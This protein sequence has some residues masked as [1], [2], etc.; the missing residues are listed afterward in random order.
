[1]ELRDAPIGR[2]V[3]LQFSFFNG[4]YLNI[5]PV[6]D[7]YGTFSK[8]AAAIV[9]T[10]VIGFFLSLPGY[11]SDFL[12]MG[13]FLAAFIVM[14]WL[15]TIPRYLRELKYAFLLAILI[16]VFA[17]YL[18][19]HWLSLE[20]FLGSLTMLVLTE[21]FY[22]RLLR[23]R[24]RSLS[25]SGS[26]SKRPLLPEGLQQHSLPRSLVI[27][28]TLPSFTTLVLSLVFPATFLWILPLPSVAK[29]FVPPALVT[30]AA[31]AWLLI[32]T[33]LQAWSLKRKLPIV[34]IALIW[35]FGLSFFG[36]NFVHEVRELP[37][38]AA[39]ID[40]ASRAINARELF[41]LWLSSRPGIAD[42]EAAHRPYPV[43]L[44]AAEGGGIRAAYQTAMLL[45]LLSQLA[46]KMRYF[47]GGIAREGA[48]I[49]EEAF[50]SACSADQVSSR[51]DNSV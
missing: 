3:F 41:R 18:R 7:A 1:L 5:H 8:K 16:G 44:V 31:S 49:K 24:K 17:S 37:R 4:F 19:A 2:T 42:Y 21:Y 28:G 20:F 10:L 27:L 26:S 29:H 46:A 43:I 14:L 11:S 51:Q 32:L 25:N 47:S 12:T 39:N 36:W 45:A 38:T 35:G 22:I 23:A 9:F 30:A 50:Q 15:E 40:P 48:S 6:M 34:A 13:M 33:E